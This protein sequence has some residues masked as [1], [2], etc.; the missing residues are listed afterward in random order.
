LSSCEHL[1]YFHSNYH[2][3]IGFEFWRCTANFD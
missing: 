3:S 2:L 1:K